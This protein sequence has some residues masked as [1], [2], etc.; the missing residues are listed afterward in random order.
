MKTTLK[1]KRTQK[2]ENK[3]LLKNVNPGQCVRFF[4]DPFDDAIYEE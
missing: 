4:S 2:E 1:R 3:V